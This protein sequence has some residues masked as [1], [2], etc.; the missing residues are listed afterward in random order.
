MSRTIDEKVVEMRFENSQFEKGIAESISS[1]NNLKENLRFDSTSVDT[2]N[3]TSNIQSIGSSVDT[4]SEKFTTFGILAH[5]ALVKVAE[6][7]IDMGMKWKDNIMKGVTEGYGKYEKMMESI[8]TIM[9][10]TRQDWE[11]TGDQMDYV[12]SQIEK[13]NWYTD[14]TSYNL[15]DMTNNIGK[16]VSAGIK[17]DDATSAMMGIANWAAISGANSEQASRAMYNLSQAMGMGVLTIADWKSIENANMATREF[18]QA[19]IDVGV[20]LGV[21]KKKGDFTYFEKK[22]SKGTKKITVDVNN[23]RTSLSEGKWLNKDVL[24]AV[25]KRYGDFSEQLY[26]TV[27]DTG[28]TATELLGHI[29]DYKEALANGE[30][31]DAWVK[32]LADKENV[33]G[34]KALADGLAA[35][36]TSYMDLGRQAFMAGQE[37]KTFKDVTLAVA[38]AVGSAWMG[39]FTAIF[40][41]YQESKE[42]WSDV[43]EEMYEIMVEPINRVRR[44]FE[45]WNIL[46]GRKDLIGGL[47]NIWESVKAIMNAFEEAFDNALPKK[48]A[49]YWSNVT[50]DF[51]KFTEDLRSILADAGYESGKLHIV[52]ENVA[53]AFS[54]MVESFSRIARA[55]KYAWQQIFP[56]KGTEEFSDLRI[57]IRSVLETLEKLTDGLV[58]FMQ[59]IY[60]SKERMD[61]LTRTFAGFFAVLDIVKMLIIACIKPFRDVTIETGNMVDPILDVTASIGDWLVALR[62]WIKENEIFDKA[63]SAIVAFLKQLPV[64][65]DKATMAMFGMHLDEVWDLVCKAVL[66]AGYVV[67]E[68]FKNLPEYAN[69]ATQELF[70]TDLQGFWELLGQWILDTWKA[71]IDFCKDLPEKINDLSEFLFGCEFKDW[72]TNI[73]EW[74]SE[75][76]QKLIDFFTEVQE[77]AED[78]WFKLVDFFNSIPEKMDDISQRLFGK[79][80]DQVWEDTKSWF[81]TVGTTIK[82]TATEIAKFFGIIDWNEYDENGNAI[83]KISSDS[84]FKVWLDSWLPDLEDFAD[85]IHD[86]MGSPQWMSLVGLVWV[87]GAIAVVWGMKKVVDSCKGLSDSLQGFFG[88]GKQLEKLKGTKWD[89]IGGVLKTFTSEIAEN[90]KGIG[91]EAKNFIKYAGWKQ[92]AEALLMVAG[93]LFLI[94]RIPIENLMIS[95]GVLVLLAGAM[96]GLIRAT[97]HLDGK[98]MIAV[99]SAFVAFGASALL[100]ASALKILDGCD[101]IGMIPSV[102]ALGSLLGILGGITI[103]IDKAGLSGEKLAAIAASMVIMSV[104]VVALA[105]AIVLVSQVDP[106]KMEAATVCLGLF[107]GAMG[108]LMIALDKTKVGVATMLAFGGAITLIG[109]GAALAGL[110]IKMIV[111]SIVKLSQLDHEAIDNLIYGIRSFFDELPALATNVGVALINFLKVLNDNKETIW[112]S[113]K[114]VVTGVLLAISAGVPIIVDIL[115]DLFSRLLDK[116]NELLPK[117]TEFLGNL[118][119]NILFIILDATPKLTTVFLT[120]LLDTL[121]QIDDNIGM[122]VMRITTISIKLITGAIKGIT[123]QLPNIIETGWQFV[124]AFINGIADGIDKH[125]EELHAALV[126][127]GNAIIDGVMVVLGI[128][129]DKNE[130]SVFRDMAGDSV[131]G[132]INGI[133]E[134]IGKAKEEITTLAN[135][136]ITTFKKIFGINSPS[137]VFADAGNDTVRGLINGIQEF[138]GKAKEEI[139]TLANSVINKFKEKLGIGSDG[140]SSEFIKMA[141]NVISGFVKGIT[142]KA[143]TAYK[144]VRSWASNIIDTVKK[145]FDTHSPSKV[146]EQI[147]IFFDEGFING[148]VKLIPK[149]EDAVNNLGDSAINSLTSTLNGISDIILTEVEDPTIKPVLDLTDVSTGMSVLE[150]MFNADRSISLAADSNTGVNNKIAAQ[151][152]QLEAIE[153]IQ[154]KLGE[155]SENQ[156]GITQNNNFYITSDNPQEVA[157]YVENRIAVNVDRRNAAWGL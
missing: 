66:Y 140:K 50:H 87:A 120:L 130:A 11:D 28:L 52:A 2:S 146:L 84:P 132:F 135:A 10:A 144:S 74:V 80:W 7:I 114:M 151:N 13:L 34:V 42:L 145:K 32:N 100:L 112:E 27:E 113:V 108:G 90:F 20:E 51:F 92:I 33:S 30:D 45:T 4:I 149:V 123:E 133:Q 49:L 86:F 82:D 17:L 157:D 91:K 137:T 125:A 68:F 118:L 105:S 46:G 156:N 47:W 25:L 35:L 116:G 61:K 12:S 96:Y 62:D 94:S 106:A 78:A 59:K 109:A 1:L 39:I 8:Q 103:G 64:Y 21:L 148:V 75:T 102:I 128:A 24:T 126:K 65:A 71:T 29:E 155:T 44:A 9:Y 124:L 31:M 150:N 22:L 152:R 14:E 98:Q 138:I 76:K 81:Q 26:K 56:S 142:D 99:G 18:K 70:G 147:G 131:R 40:G 136:I 69:Q 129:K 95:V 93:A 119:D 79:N 97:E 85:E 101:P 83:G 55:V 6:S 36:S 43:A 89:I 15:T 58:N 141:G 53:K 5:T 134:W 115:A 60:I 54:L 111:D 153:D 63:V 117:L 127:L 104:A 110:G 38:D 121:Q 48:S 23:F 41:N 73:K 139:T 3:I 88:L 143:E 77:G 37:C 72:W 57:G 154:S 67:F 122:I 107:I 16:F 19:A